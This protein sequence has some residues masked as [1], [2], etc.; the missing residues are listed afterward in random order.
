MHSLLTDHCAA[1]ATSSE[2]TMWQWMVMSNNESENNAAGSVKY[3]NSQQD[4]CCNTASQWN[5]CRC[6]SRIGYSSP[7]LVRRRDSQSRT[8][9]NLSSQHCSGSCRRDSWRS[10]S[11]QWCWRTYLGRTASVRSGRSARRSCLT[12]QVDMLS[13]WSLACTC[14]PHTHYIRPDQ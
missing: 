12:E 7:G 14:P 1:R 5:L 6:H 10:G 2:R 8:I 9:G 3:S 11:V 13:R 4:S